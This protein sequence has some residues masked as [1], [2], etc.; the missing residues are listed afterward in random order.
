MW[1]IADTGFVSIV[2]HEDNPDILIVR[3]RVARD[4]ETLFGC[5]RDD[6]VTMPGADYLYRAFIPRWIVADVLWEKVMSLDYTSHSKDIAIARSPK[7]PGRTKAYYAIWHAL[8]DLQ[9]IPPY[10]TTRRRKK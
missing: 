4:I 9:P 3:A 10:A 1:L 5:T 7:A 2:V 8:A 6:I